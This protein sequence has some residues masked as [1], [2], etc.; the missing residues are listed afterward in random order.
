MFRI[1][2]DRELSPIFREGSQ[3]RQGMYDA[4]NDAEI[5]GSLTP[6]ESAL[7][8]YNR[9]IEEFAYEIFKRVIWSPRR[10]VKWDVPQMEARKA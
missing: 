1:P 7:E 8:E 3:S 9:S 2:L 10:L 5:S 6:R 4:I